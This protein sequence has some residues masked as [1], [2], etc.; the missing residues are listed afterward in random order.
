MPRPLNNESL[1]K[2]I[3]WA[4]DDVTENRRAREDLLRAR[5]D[6][7]AAN[8]AKSEFLAA[9]SHEIRTPMNAIVGMTDITLQTDLTGDQ[10]DYLHTVQDS[11][12]H[13]LSLI[14]DILDLSKIEAQKLELDHSDFDLPFHVETTIKGLD[15]QARQKGLDLLLH[16][17]ESISRCV[18]GD[19]LSLRQVLVNLVGNAIKFTH[20]GRIEVRL[21]SASGKAPSE[22]LEEGI[23]VTFEVED[24]GIGIPPGIPGLDIPELF[25]D[26]PRF[27]RNGPGLGHLQATHRAHGRRDSR[28]LHRGQ[29]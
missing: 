2:G 21:T 20:R 26:H 28:G 10:R 24:T 6:A 14:N 19:A 17:D 15:L 11:A 8:R 12:R 25:P 29:G 16:I 7:E 1:D 3:I 27:R 9:M 22:S 23:G 18:R 5:E 13:L 4:W